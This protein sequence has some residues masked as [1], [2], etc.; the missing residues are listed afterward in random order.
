MFHRVSK[1]SNR[2]DQGELVV[3]G[4]TRFDIDAK[5]EVILVEGYLAGADGELVVPQGEGGVDA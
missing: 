3:H 5:I 2:I 4:F 1:Q